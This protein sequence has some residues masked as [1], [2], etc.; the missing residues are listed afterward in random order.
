MSTWIIIMNLDCLI[1]AILHWY[2]WWGLDGPRR[3]TLRRYTIS[4]D[5]SLKSSNVAHTS[6]DRRVLASIGPIYTHYSQ[7]SVFFDLKVLPGC[8][9][10]LL[11]ISVILILPLA[12]QLGA[13]HVVRYG[14][15]TS[16]GARSR[17]LAWKLLR[18]KT[19]L[20]GRRNMDYSLS[21]CRAKKSE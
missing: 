21:D 13:V 2:K 11:V 17:M 1:K 5:V 9:K 14:S 8:M 19:G 18:G 10:F 20:F 7:L 16:S 12:D 6:Q 3:N 15:S 4:R